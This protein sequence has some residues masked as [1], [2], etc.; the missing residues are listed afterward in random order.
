MAARRGQA[1]FFGPIS[2]PLS[3]L[4]APLQVTARLWPT[5]YAA[6]ALRG[7][8]RGEP[9]DHIRPPVAVLAGFVVLSLALIPRRLAWR[10]R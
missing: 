5:T 4:P 8:V 9:W 2:Y 7:A 6:E 3:A 10:A 1:P